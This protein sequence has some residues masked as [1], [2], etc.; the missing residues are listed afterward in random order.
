M[1]QRDMNITPI[2]KHHLEKHPLISS[3]TKNEL[4]ELE[5]NSKLKTI[6]KGNSVPLSIH[7]N[8]VYIVLS[9]CLKIFEMNLNGQSLVKEV[10]KKGG[11]FGAFLSDDPDHLEYATSSS[12]Q[13]VLCC[14]SYSVINRIT[15]QNHTFSSHLN[16]MVSKKLRNI[17][18]RYRN[19]I[20]SRS[21]E[22]RLINLLKQWAEY[23]GEK[24]GSKTIL[25]VSL[26]HEELA[27]MIGSTRATVTAI[28]N[29]LRDTGEIDYHKGRIEIKNL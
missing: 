12:E 20:F 8:T 25:N 26:T 22:K 28:L 13:A 5:Q 23:E 15:L 10:L 17:E 7:S 18:N 24:K 9:G 4:L 6:K 14:L 21:I 29:Q 11:V 19:V 3:L 2:I 27:S 1:I 16:H